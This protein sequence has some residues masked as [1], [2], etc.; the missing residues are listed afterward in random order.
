MN[1]NADYATLRMRAD[2]NKRLARLPMA[3]HNMLRSRFTKRGVTPSSASD[4]S[5][6]ISV[7]MYVYATGMYV[8]LRSQ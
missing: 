3:K 4:G 8:L 7:H 1:R 6:A 2:L 5:P